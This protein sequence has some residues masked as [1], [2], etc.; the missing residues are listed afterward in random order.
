VITALISTIL[1]LLSFVV[2]AQSQTLKVWEQNQRLPATFD[3]IELALE[4][5]EPKYGHYTIETLPASNVEQAF[6]LL[7]TPGS[8]DLIVSGNEKSRESQA[9]PIYI[10][11]DRGLLGF[12]LCLINKQ[13]AEV[14]STISTA[15][16]FTERN[17]AIYVKQQWP[18]LG[19]YENN[20]FPVQGF[21]QLTSLT[22]A[23]TSDRNACFSRS[24]IEIGFEAMRY[25]NLEIEANVA[26]IYPLADIIYVSK[27]NTRLQAAL[28]YG[29][30]KAIEDQSYFHLFNQHYESVLQEHS[31]YFR[32]MFLM[33]NDEVSPS[34]LDAINKYGIA[35]FN[36]Q[37]EYEK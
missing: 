32:K 5:A 9:Y 13:S 1:S 27:A 20:G 10:P 29:L 22:N 8:L 25:Q 19:I 26:F 6:K 33:K 30:N 3:F 16:E 14:F 4:K 2:L 21:N 11:L 15:A 28:E 12:R 24:L 35:S 7:N 18:D 31:F 23:L 34:A 36:K 17:L 37:F